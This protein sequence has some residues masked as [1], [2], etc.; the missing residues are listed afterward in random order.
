MTYRWPD[1]ILVDFGH[2]LDLEFWGKIWNILCF[3]HWSLCSHIFLGSVLISF[4]LNRI[5][6][7]LIGFWLI[8]FVTL[9][10]SFQGQIL[11]SIYLRTGWSDCHETKTEFICEMGGM[12]CYD[13]HW[14]WMRFWPWNFKVSYRNY[15]YYI[16]P[17]TS[18]KFVIGFTWCLRGGSFA[19]LMP[20]FTYELLVILDKKHYILVSCK[21]L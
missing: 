13:D 1:L 20:L 9:I 8:L 16:F 5:I 7:Y 2:D 21:Q 11:E 14:L 12:V 17:C 4:I 10:L 18:I 15:M 19:S 6:E 3:F